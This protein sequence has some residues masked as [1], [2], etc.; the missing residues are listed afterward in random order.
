MFGHAGDSRPQKGSRHWSW[1]QACLDI[2]Y[3][4]FAEFKHASQLIFEY[5]VA[6]TGDESDPEQLA[7]KATK[8]RNGLRKNLEN[9]MV[10]KASVKRMSLHMRLGELS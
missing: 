4:G 5:V 7:A 1:W 6:D 9:Q 10:Y 3:E 8:L 2:W